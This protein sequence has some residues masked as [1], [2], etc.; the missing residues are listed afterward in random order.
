MVELNQLLYITP[1]NYHS[2]G[3]STYYRLLYSI[4]RLIEYVTIHAIPLRRNILCHMAVLD[5]QNNV[6]GTVT[7]KVFPGISQPHGNFE[8]LPVVPKNYP[9]LHLVKNFVK[10]DLAAVKLST[11]ISL[12]QA[13]A[14]EPVITQ[15][16]L[17]ETAYRLKATS[18]LQY[19]NS[20]KMPT[21]TLAS[22]G[23][24]SSLIQRRVSIQEHYNLPHTMTHKDAL[25]HVY[26]EL[27]KNDLLDEQHIHPRQLLTNTLSDAQW[28]SLTQPQKVTA[29]LRSLTWS[30][31]F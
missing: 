27:I 25:N 28:E 1:R 4:T 26:K 24:I 19:P 31:N 30:T 11:E 21:W 18:T 8:L 12:L 2:C 17:P 29:L 5:Q 13:Y 16:Q 22:K 23:A 15:I 14:K 10:L 20:L 7:S 9:N 6:C 3:T